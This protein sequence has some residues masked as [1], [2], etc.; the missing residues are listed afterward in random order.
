MTDNLQPRSDIET[1]I[2]TKLIELIALMY[3]VLDFR[4]PEP[5]FCN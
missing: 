5:P 3:E 1:T 2:R 4:D